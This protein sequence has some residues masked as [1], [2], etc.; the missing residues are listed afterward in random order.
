[1]NVIEVKNLNKNYGHLKVLDN[2]NLD[3]AEGEILGF[4]GPNGTGK[5]TAISAMIGSIAYQSGTITFFGKPLNKLSKEERQSIGI[6]PQEI[7]IFSELSVYDNIY[8]FA[9]LNGMEKVAAKASTLEVIQLLGLEDKTK[10]RTAK[11]STG[12]RVRV[13]IACGIVH[14]PKILFL[15]EPT[16]AIDPQSRNN[17]MTIIKDLNKNGTTIIY[18]SH[19]MEE[20][21]LL[22]NKIAIMDKGKVIAYGTKEQLLDMISASLTVSFFSYDAP[23]KITEVLSQFKGI[24]DLNFDHSKVKLGVDKDTQIE[25]II[26]LLNENDIAYTNFQTEAKNLQHI[27]IQLT[28]NT[29]RD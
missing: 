10:V 29:L 17:I 9:R 8:Y 22:C 16:V 1:M 21:E 25:G 19:Y 23:E 18:T 28:G 15:D 26:S 13:N 20:V 14:K 5:T 6:V 3:V 7:A 24:M 27:F 4:L 11:L 12:L 2:L